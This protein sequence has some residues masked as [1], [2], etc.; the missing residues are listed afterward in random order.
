MNEVGQ[1][2]Y[3]K[4]REIEK[5]KEPTDKKNREYE[6]SNDSNAPTHKGKQLIDAVV[7]RKV[8]KLIFITEGFTKFLSHKQLIS[9]LG[10]SPR[11]YESGI[12]VKGKSRVCK[13]GMSKIRH[14]I[15]MC[16]MTGFKT[17]IILQ[18]TL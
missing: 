9:Y 3:S 16:S 15:Y 6:T 13:M 11:I 8:C 17:N 1:L 18:R 10:L 12:S 7:F 5:Q 2:I 4:Y 14:L